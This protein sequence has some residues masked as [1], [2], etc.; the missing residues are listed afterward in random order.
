MILTKIAVSWFICGFTAFL[1]NLYND[2]VFIPMTKR[3]TRWSY[4][5]V[6]D[7]VMLFFSYT[8]GGLAALIISIR[9][10]D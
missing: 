9:P 4:G 7:N 2:L 5:P 10:E 1:F 6:R 3:Q 8:F